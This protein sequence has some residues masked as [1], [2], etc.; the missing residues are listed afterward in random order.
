[1]KTI[2]PARKIILP[3]RL[4]TLPLTIPAAIK[5]PAHTRKRIQ[6]QRWNFLSRFLFLTDIIVASG[7]LVIVRIISA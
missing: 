3:M 1:M 6:P 5:N 4:G 2:Q 7:D